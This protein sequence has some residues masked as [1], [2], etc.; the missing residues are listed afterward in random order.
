MAKRCPPGVICI[1]NIT[2]IIILLIIVCVILF[3]NLYTKTQTV[4]IKEN[5][6]PKKNG[7]FPRPS[8]SFSNISS[9]VL[10]NP[11]KA[12]LKDERIFPINDPRGVP[13]NIPTQSVDTTYRQIG[14]LTRLNGDSDM[15]LP[16]MGKPLFTNRDKWNYYTMTDKNNMIKLPIT[17]KGRSCTNEYGCD[18][19]YNGDTVYVEGYNDAFKITVYE[20]D[21]MRYIPYL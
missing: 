7:L 6:V 8:F 17:Y 19:L 15:I 12:P 5:E 13:I 16:L 1:E 9:D 18:K 4:I 20:N 11:Y 2:I 21:I 10:M 3:I 14:I